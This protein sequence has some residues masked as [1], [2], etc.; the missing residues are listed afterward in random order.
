MNKIQ[1]IGLWVGVMSYPFMMIIALPFLND[2][3]PSFIIIPF[4][5]FGAIIL[6]ALIIFSKK[7]IY[8]FTRMLKSIGVVGTGLSIGQWFMRKW[9]ILFM[10][11]LIVLTFLFTF[12]IDIGLNSKYFIKRDVNMMFTYRVTGDCDSFLNYIYSR[13]DQWEGWMDICEKEK[14]NA[15][16]PIEKFT[17]V[18]ISHRFGSDKAFVQ[19][20]HTRSFNDMRTY[21]Y[22]K[23]YE[24]IKDGL[25]WKIN[26]EGKEI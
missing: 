17:I 19:V 13:D 11:L 16:R 9:V 15:V 5:I 1:K 8:I 4:M 21:T 14:S 24:L 18:N 25:T 26:Q 10:V 6:G 20:L 3:S 23:K 22:S 7:I 2:D 12:F